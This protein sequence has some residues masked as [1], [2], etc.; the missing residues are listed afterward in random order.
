MNQQRK[1]G[2]GA[3]KLATVQTQLG[4]KASNKIGVLLMEQG[5]ARKEPGSRHAV[6][7]ASELSES[8]L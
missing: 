6:R 3:W 2:V 4:Q 5:Q 7:G 8:A 1:T